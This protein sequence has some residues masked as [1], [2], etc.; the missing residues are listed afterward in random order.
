MQKIEGLLKNEE[1]GGVREFFKQW[2]HF[3]YFIVA[4]FGPAYFGGLS[5]RKFIKKYAQEGMRLN[6][7]SGPRVVD[8]TFQN[9][10][11][12]AYASVTYVADAAHVPVE[13]NA[14]SMIISDN[15]LEH[16]FHVE[17]VVGEMKRILKSGGV[18]YVS[19]PFL[20]PFHSSPDD[21]TRFTLSGLQKLFH[22]FEIVESGVRSGI[23]STITVVL[24]YLCA[25]LFSF[26]SKKV[27][28]FLLNI[29]IF[30]FFPIKYLDS[31][32]NHFPFSEEVAS[33]FYMVVRKK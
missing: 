33:V 32:G 28:Q 29:F 19:T 31:I 22:E 24:V 14:V 30:I 5:P 17:E 8:P 23:F 26:G 10:D 16:I 21:F 1:V 12:T 25:S 11:T 27:Y 20:Y 18:A 15:V 6:I 7:G 13:D 4:V 2:P 9:V 3:Y